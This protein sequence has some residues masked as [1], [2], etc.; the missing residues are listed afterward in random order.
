[1]FLGLAAPV[2]G[3]ACTARDFMALP[4][5]Q[6]PGR[7]PVVL[8]L[9][10]AYPGLYVD[11]GQARVH[12][13]DGATVLPLGESTGQSPEALL[14]GPSIVEQFTYPYPLDFDLDARRTPWVDPGRLRN[15]AFFQA[16]YFD[17]QTEA[18]RHLRTVR[19]ATTGTSFYLT[20]KTCAATQLDAALRAIAAQGTDYSRFFQSVGGSFNW[21]RIAGTNRLSAHSFGIALDLNAKLGGYWRWSGAQPGAAQVYDNKI[22]EGIVS[23]LERYGFVWGGKWHHFDGMH[24]EYRPEL[25]LYARL[26]DRRA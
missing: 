1:M 21:R 17:R 6:D 26:L 24:F 13:P 19:Y 14:Q 5:P 18:A 3:S 9:E 8:A 4:L 10:T 12:M 25:I 2:A 22:P 15:Q 20:D 16:L 23:A 7:S 11:D